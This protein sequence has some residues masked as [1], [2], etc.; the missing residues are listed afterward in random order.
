MESIGAVYFINLDH[1]TDRLSQIQAEFGRMKIPDEKIH[2]ISGVYKPECGALGCGLSHVKTLNA[3]L[4]TT[5]TYC[6]VFE[7]DFQFT[8]DPN[9]FSFLLRHVFQSGKQFDMVML[10][11]NVMK[12]EMT[13]SPFLRRILDAQTSSAY[14]I[15]REYA[16]TVRDTLAEGMKFLE[17]WFAIHKEPKHEYCLDIYWKQLQPKGTWLVFNPKIGIQRESYSDIERKVTNYGV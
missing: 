3:F 14:L 13:D 9:Y 4:E 5:H 12:Q 8:V 16:K 11:A 1:R 10:G 17:E 7:D 15:S 6:L 2:R